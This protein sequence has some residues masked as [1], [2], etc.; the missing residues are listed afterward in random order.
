MPIAFRCAQC[1]KPYNVSDGLAGKRAACKACGHAMVIPDPVTSEAPRP[2]S[3]AS[4]QDDVPMAVVRPRPKP[5]AIA[6]AVDVYGLDEGPATSIAGDSEAAEPMAPPPPRW[7][8]KKAS[9]QPSSGARRAPT[10]AKPSFFSGISPARGIGIIVVL[11]MM[12][13]GA[14]RGSKLQPKSQI[15]AFHITAKTISGRIISDL[16]SVQD[17]PSATAASP[18]VK[19]GLTSYMNHIEE[20]KDKEGNLK[21]IEAADRIYLAQHRA[22]W[23]RIGR[24]IMRIGAMP[25][26]FVALNIRDELTRLETLQSK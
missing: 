4:R 16:G 2:A 22:D 14:I 26:A 25:E 3:I 7:A 12:V 17:V 24:E 18:R 9:S 8:T 21:D 1:Q 19:A 15:E 23:E 10:P 20:N 6:P 13:V 5:A 11:I